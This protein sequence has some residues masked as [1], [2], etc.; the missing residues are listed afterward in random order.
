MTCRAIIIT[1]SVLSSIMVKNTQLFLGKQVIESVFHSPKTMIKALFHVGKLKINYEQMIYGEPIIYID[2][3]KIRYRTIPFFRRFVPNY[4][5]TYLSTGDWDRRY[6]DKNK[7]Y[8]QDYLNS[9]RESRWGDNQKLF[10]KEFPQ[11]MTLVPICKFDQYISY[12]NHFI[13]G[14]PWEDTLFY[15]RRIDEGFNTSRY[16]SEQG[17]LRRLEF[18]DELYQRIKSEGYKT[19]QE[20]KAEGDQQAG[21]WQHEV[22]INIGRSGELILDDGRNRLI[23]AKLLEIEKI[24]VRVLVRHEQWRDIQKKINNSSRYNSLPPNLQQYT[25]HPDLDVMGNK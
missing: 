24:P 10:P 11:K 4:H 6:A 15:K 12:K 20:L 2:P 8:P 17:L 16:S 22:Q 9:G 13:N 5:L 25:N 23:L 19:Q 7:I 14:V 21:G 3:N 18:I 1:Q